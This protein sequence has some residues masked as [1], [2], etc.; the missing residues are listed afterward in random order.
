[1]KPF[2]HLH[3]HTEYSLLDGAI[4]IKDLFPFLKESGMDAVA[5]TDHGN[6]FGVINFYTEAK[7]HG[8]KPIIGCEVYVAPGSRKDR[9][10]ES[11]NA[12]LILLAMDNE[13]YKNLTKLVSYG[14]IDGFYYKP[15][16]D[17]ELLKAHN[18]GLIA[19]SACIE[20]VVAKRI[21]SGDMD[22]AI[23]KAKLFR[24]I[25][26]DRFFLEV[27]RNG[28]EEQEVVNEGLKDISRMLSIPLVATNDCHYLLSSDYRVHDVLLCIQTGKKLSDENRLKFSSDQLYVKTPEEMYD[29][30]H[31]MEEA[32][33]ITSTI[34][35][36]C[37]VTFEFGKHYLPRFTPPEGMGLD[38]YLEKRAK[39]GLKRR[40][41]E[42]KIPRERLSEYEERLEKELSIIKK[43]GFSGYF[44][45]VQDFISYAKRK[46]I[47][48]GPGR[49]SAAG[50][51]V[52]FCL[53]ITEVDP[54]RW[55][56]L[57]ERFLNPDRVTLP[58][59][60]VD[61]CKKRRDEV[62]SYVREKYGA[63][64]VSQ[65]ITFGTLK[66][67]AVVRDVGRVLGM[68]YSEVDKIAKLIPPNTKNLR[69]AVESDPML[70]KVYE[71]K[72]AVRELIDIA[73]KLEGLPRHAST[74][75]A[76]VVISD[77][78]IMEKIPLYRSAKDGENELV[79]QF[80]M[81]DVEKVG[82]V[83]FDFLGLNNLTII[84]E[85]VRLIKEKTGKAIDIN[86]IPLDDEKTYELLSSGDT[87]GV[88]QLESRGMRDLLR[89]TKP[90]KF[91][92]LI[93][94]LALYRPGPIESGMVREYIERKNGR[95]KVT[96]PYKGL[97][98]ILK[99]TYGVIV[100]QEQVMQIA[101]ALAGFS[102]S[103]ADVLRKAMAKKEAK[104]MGELREK[105][106][107]GAVKNGVPKEKAEE[108]FDAISKFGRYGFNKS[109]SA[110]YAFI[111]Y[112]TAYL[113]ANYPLYFFASLLT[114]ES[115]NTDK[116]ISY[117]AEC[118][119]K[120]IEVLPPDINESDK[121]FT[122]TEEGKIRFGFAAIKDVG[123]AAI[124]EILREREKGPFTGIE[125]FIERVNPSKVNRKV[126]ERL[127]KAGAFDSFGI[128]RGVLF[129]N[130]ENLMKKSSRRG[131]K[132]ASNLMSFLG[133]DVA[134]KKEQTLKGEDW[135][136]LKMLRYE[137]ESLGFFVS[138]HPLDMYKEK[139]SDLGI[140]S[141]REAK[142]PS[143]RVSVV[144]LTRS[145]KTITK[146]GE[147]LGIVTIEDKTG[148]LEVLVPPRKFE[149]I[150]FYLSDRM[151]PFFFSGRLRDDGD[152]RR[153]LLLAD[154][155]DLLENV[156]KENQKDVC[157]R[158]D[159]GSFPIGSV[160]KLRKMVEENKG[161][162][163]LIFEITIPGAGRVKIEAGNGFRVKHLD[164]PE[165]LIKSL[166]EGAA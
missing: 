127:I 139:L 98:S 71:E 153:P 82:L 128:N 95:K 80:D 59:I 120:G 28:M 117:I 20:G 50:S 91:E 46:G 146:N 154:K 11:K 164:D 143:E 142:G 102:L 145:V 69:E 79:T 156:I 97:E 31:D 114:C 101:S 3:L 8:I 131:A 51:L 151:E 42:G 147:K 121:Y 152:G 78:P 57:F 88:F 159:G 123:D 23:E 15:R 56:L 1:M 84:D 132:R 68:S 9:T 7:N 70:K 90:T 52:A 24:E 108:I 45:I 75:A 54:I 162:R 2:V 62:V 144:G 124:D 38:E 73:S 76:G 32:V 65:I 113:K 125:D 67:R 19:M 16:I 5:I 87:T 21:L 81:G 85:T 18:K 141:C 39:D 27:Q 96:Y 94:L 93:T 36:K 138:G 106:I 126:V 109:H 161:D 157:I 150:Y 29:L 26:G 13:G 158:I 64:C 111:S 43:M 166:Q 149:E 33:S 55:G 135:D 133:K 100:Y 122:V 130:L 34:A 165:A 105:F 14:Y 103:E 112:Q 48:V 10:S 104:N 35:E 116:I 155:A 163:K 17:E 119:E 77:T 63:Q 137:K 44:L 86:N 148:S 134:P 99:E 41:D 107:E 30:F 92:D 37:N 74:H 25:F 89:S 40:L 4:R 53:G 160:G 6:M 12:H 49:G 60:D 118:R 115:H 110:A 129:E 58:D 136:M 66:A 22:G 61:F 140:T 72:S 47:P 83:K